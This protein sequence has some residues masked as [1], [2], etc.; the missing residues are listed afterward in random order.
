MRVSQTVATL[1]ILNV[2]AHNL[3]LILHLAHNKP[4]VNVSG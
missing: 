4:L 2:F 3:N 1:I